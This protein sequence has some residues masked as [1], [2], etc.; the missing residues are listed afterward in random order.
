MKI[1]GLNVCANLID[2]STRYEPDPDWVFT[3]ALGKEHRWVCGDDRKWHLPSLEERTVCECSDERECSADELPCSGAAC[4]GCEMYDFVRHKHEE[5]FVPET[6]E[7]VKPGYRMSTGPK[8]IRGLME[9]S[10]EY[11]SDEQ[12]RC[13]DG[14]AYRFEDCDIPYA[15]VDIHGRFYVTSCNLDNDGVYRGSWRAAGEVT[16]SARV[17]PT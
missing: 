5:L 8:Y 7:V 10:G 9:C 12:P 13:G 14:E 17:S 3:D 16:Q 2:A 6:G 15:D 4:E 11:E 1:T